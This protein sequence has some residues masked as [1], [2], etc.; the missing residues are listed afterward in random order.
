M[1]LAYGL[2]VFA[3]SPFIEAH[4]LDHPK[5]ESASALAK[6]RPSSEGGFQEQDLRSSAQAPLAEPVAAKPPQITY[7]DGQLTIVAENSSL[8]EVMKALRSVLGAEIELPASAANQRIWTHLGPGPARRVLR[9]LLDG[10]EFNYVIQASQD[11]ENGVQSVMLTLRTK[12]GDTPGSPAGAEVAKNR[13]TPNG[14]VNG[15]AESENPSADAVVPVDSLP[16]ADSTPANSS[17]PSTNQRTAAANQQNAA[18]SLDVGSPGVGAPGSE[19]MI[20][21]LQSMYQQRRQIQAQQSQKPSG[22]N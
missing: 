10:T 2:A 9:D 19:Q 12:P 14:A 6:E 5:I 8:T 3:G 1:T 17:P 15:A 22:P 11:D 7:Q 16:S 4:R 18:A 13:R 20:Q 21:Q